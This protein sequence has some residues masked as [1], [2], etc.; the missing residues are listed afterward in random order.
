M[1]AVVW[2]TALVMQLFN[3]QIE[4]QLIQALY[5]LIMLGFDII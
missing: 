2:P 1:P 3:T 4:K 5:I